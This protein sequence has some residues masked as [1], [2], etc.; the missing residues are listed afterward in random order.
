MTRKT[1]L[2]V[3]GAAVGTLVL[4][5]LAACGA[6]Q[7]GLSELP[8]GRVVP[9]DE[10]AAVYGEIAPANHTDH[11]GSGPMVYFTHDI[12]PTTLEAI[13]AALG[14]ALGEGKVGVKLSTGEPGS[15]HL[16]TDLIA[17][18]VH[19][20]NGTIVE[21]NTAYDGPRDN[22][23]SHYAVTADHGYSKIADFQIMDEGGSYGLPVKGGFHLSE[24]L[25]GAHFP[26]YDAFV[27]LLHFKGHQMAGFGGAL[28]NLSIGMASAAGK[29]RIHSAGAV[30]LHT[31]ISAE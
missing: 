22:T 31:V 30:E 20:V 2:E 24:N 21:C 28:K 13:Y 14:R 8:D 25:V 17:D 6:K 3:G 29:F 7:E 12:S 27:I 1:F 18:L 5:G 10:M 16:S 9:Y 26:D 23:E 11:A 4:G 15:N 19:S